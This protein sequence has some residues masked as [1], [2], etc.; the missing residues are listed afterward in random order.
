MKALGYLKAN[1]GNVLI[2]ASG[3]ITPENVR[4]Y[5]LESV[6]I[7]SLSALVQGYPSVDYSMKVLSP[8]N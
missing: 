8:Q 3:G 4:S 7:I 5:A 1:F 6:D 2:E